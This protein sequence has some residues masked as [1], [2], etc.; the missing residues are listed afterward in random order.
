[1]CVEAFASCLRAPRAGQRLHYE[2]IS[3]KDSQ[4]PAKAR[5]RCAGEHHRVA[6]QDQHPE[7]TLD[8]SRH[9]CA[10]RTACDTA[11]VLPRGSGTLELQLLT[12]MAKTH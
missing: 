3:N 5:L 8:L 1:M 4:G 7:S 12:W 2:V 6:S 9:A 11:K 10:R